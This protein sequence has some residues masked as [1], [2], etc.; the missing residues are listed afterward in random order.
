[1]SGL[2]SH[3]L[4]RFANDLEIV[5]ERGPFAVVGQ[6]Q[7]SRTRFPGPV[8]LSRDSL[9]CHR[10]RPVKSG[11]PIRSPEWIIWP[12]APTIGPSPRPI[13]VGKGNRDRGQEQTGKAVRAEHL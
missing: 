12:P 8:K 11:T 1:M 9:V 6:A 13:P 7:P 2:G 5:L 3:L 10:W 4:R